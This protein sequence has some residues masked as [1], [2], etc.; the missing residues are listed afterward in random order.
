MNLTRRICL[1]LAAVVLT[2]PWIGAD[3]LK[4]VKGDYTFYGESHH[5]LEDCRRMALEGARIEALKAE[6]GTTVSN[7]TYSRDNADGDSYF[8]SL[9]ATEVRGEWIADDGEPRF[10]VNIDDQGHY[11]VR[12]IVAGHARA[13]ANEA[14]DFEAVPL[15]GGMSL[16]SR[17]TSFE[18]GDDLRLYFRAPVDGTISVFLIDDSHTVWGLLPYSSDSSGE[19][20][21]RRGKE[22]VFF[23][24]ESGD[25]ASD[26]AMVDEL[27]LTTDREVERNEL[28]VV[29]SPNSFSIP[30]MKTADG[31][32]GSMS[33]D[34]FNRWIADS[35]R[36]D[37]KMG[38]RR[39]GL[40]I[41]GNKAN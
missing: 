22:Y 14:V 8:S 7:D 19:V 11:I 13:I 28:Y 1:S 29:F 27:T 9:S 34:S 41:T 4:K 20:R 36:R 21:V 2:A 3:N 33:L 40:E 24:T 23:S 30:G 12:C 38:V 17:T 35:R 37:A 32:P 39:I 26:R 15:R 5:S 10:E 6:Y 25:G 31:M 18:S 16:A